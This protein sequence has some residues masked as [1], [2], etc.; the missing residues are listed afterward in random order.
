MM[1]KN[2]V[3][4]EEGNSARSFR[5]GKVLFRD[6]F[7]LSQKPVLYACNV[8]KMIS[9]SEIIRMFSRLLSMLAHRVMKLLVFVQKLRLN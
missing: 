3:H 5:D 6:L 7:L 4:L 2:I 1:Q 8:V 9:L